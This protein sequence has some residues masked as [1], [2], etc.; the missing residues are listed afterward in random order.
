MCVQVSDKMDGGQL[1]SLVAALNPDNVPG[2]LT[3]IVRM[4]ADKVRHLA[5]FRVKGLYKGLKHP[6]CDCYSP[7]IKM[8]MKCTSCIDMPVALPTPVLLLVRRTS[9]SSSSVLTQALKAR[10]EDTWQF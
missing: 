3:V 1:V 2:L 10:S 9:F 7:C 6:Q 5:I 4:G 8:Q